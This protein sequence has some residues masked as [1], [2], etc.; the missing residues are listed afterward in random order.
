LRP[1]LILA[2]AIPGQTRVESMR[3]ERTPRAGVDVEVVVN[4]ALP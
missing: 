2:Q 1:A 3:T 4:R